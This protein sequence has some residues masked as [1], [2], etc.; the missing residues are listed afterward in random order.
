MLRGVYRLLRPLL[1]LL[2]AEAAHAVVG[3]ALWL[4]SRVAPRPR[5]RERLAQTLWGLRFPNPVGL[6]AGMDKGHSPRG[7]HECLPAQSRYGGLGDGDCAEQLCSS[8]YNG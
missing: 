6:A 1:F 2:P 8:M 4:W 7:A 3:A 5:V